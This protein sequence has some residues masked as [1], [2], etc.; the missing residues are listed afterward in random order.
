MRS[1][2]LVVNKQLAE[3]SLRGD[4]RV[5]RT[6]TFFWIEPVSAKVGAVRYQGGHGAE[7]GLVDG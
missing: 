1:G 7:I 6:R 3:M 5:T 4:E 2:S